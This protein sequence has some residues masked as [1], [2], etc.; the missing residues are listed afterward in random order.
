MFPLLGS[1]FSFV[2]T[3]VREKVTILRD[4][5]AS[6]TDSYHSVKKMTT[7]ECGIAT[8]GTSPRGSRTLLRLH[9]A[10]EFLIAFVTAVRESEKET[11]MAALCRDAYK[12]TLAKHHPWI[13]RQSVH[14][15]S[16]TLS[17]RHALIRVRCPY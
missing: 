8:A 14:L 2:Q 9:R 4:L 10:L 3:D 5:H 6:H 11:K 13:V 15:A 1:V 12:R 17:S 7:T 16:Y